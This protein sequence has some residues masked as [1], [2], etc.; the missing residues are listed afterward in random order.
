MKR[1]GTYGFTF[2]SKAEEWAAW[3]WGCIQHNPPKTIDDS[4][5]MW[6]MMTNYEFDA[7]EDSADLTRASIIA[8][9]AQNA[10]HSPAQQQNG[11]E[12]GVTT[13]RPRNRV[14]WPLAAGGAVC[15]TVALVLASQAGWL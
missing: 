12:I 10:R 2:D 8:Q 5:R 4:N 13:T 11:C 7:L 9:Y 6:R 14:L 3:A 1:Q 15:V